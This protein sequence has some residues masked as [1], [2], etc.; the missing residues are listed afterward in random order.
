MPAETK[1]IL[2]PDTSGYFDG[3]RSEYLSTDTSDKATAE[4]NHLNYVPRLTSAANTNAVDDIYITN[5]KQ[6]NVLPSSPRPAGSGNTDPSYTPLWQVSQVTWVQGAQAETLTSEKAIL[7]AQASGL[8]TIA[9][10]N[11]VINC[12]V[13]Y[14]PSGG[15]LQDTYVFDL[16]F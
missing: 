14:T 3:Q 13:V 1:I 15:E 10:T 8:V 12:P 11:V 9:K 5:A 2:A 16:P 6:P 4:L 7:A